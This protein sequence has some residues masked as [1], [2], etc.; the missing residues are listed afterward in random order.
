VRECKKAG[1]QIEIFEGFRSPD[2][3]QRLYNQ[4]RVNAERVITY[5]KPWE[6]WH[7]YGLAVDIAL[8][9]DPGP[10]KQWYWSRDM[11]IYKSIAEVFKTYGF[12][13]GGLRDAGHY[14]A[15]GDLTVAEAKDLMD[16]FGLQGL[17][18]I[19]EGVCFCGRSINR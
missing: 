3:Q 15:S 8:D 19:A 4:G 1:Y 9:T 2:R 18:T 10:K 12:T 7:Q 6:S 14:Q 16:K 13:W 11:E 5:A 17:W